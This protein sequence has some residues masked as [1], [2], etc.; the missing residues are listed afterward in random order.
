MSGTT[1]GASR[2]NETANTV[3]AR[4]LRHQAAG[5]GERLCSSP[6]GNSLSR[7]PGQK[8]SNMSREWPRFGSRACRPAGRGP[9]A[10]RQRLTLQELFDFAPDGYLVTDQVRDHFGGQPRGR[11]VVQRTPRNLYSASRSAC[12]SP[13]GPG[14]PS[15]LSDRPNRPAR[16]SPSRQAAGPSAEPRPTAACCPLGRDAMTGEEGRPAGFR[17]VMRDVT[18]HPADRA[19]R[20]GS[21]ASCSTASSAPPRRLSS[22]WT[23]RAGCCASNAVSARRFPASPGEV[24]GGAVLGRG[25]APAGRPAGRPAR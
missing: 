23:R 7:P 9:G 5:E 14:R 25:P 13:R 2:D 6:S 16:G 17:W 20:C 1:V 3:F 12:S 18:P 21:S 22:S 8:E 19:G 24:A 4:P 15:Q 10:Q 11:R